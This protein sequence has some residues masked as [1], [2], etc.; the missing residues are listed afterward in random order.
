MN[1]KQLFKKYTDSDNEY[2]QTLLTIYRNIGEDIYQLLENAEKEDKEL[3][4]NDSALPQ[5]WDEFS[6]EDVILK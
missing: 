5:V 2:A 4:I 6:V 3:A 1:G